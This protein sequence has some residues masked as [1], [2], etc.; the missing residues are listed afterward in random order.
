MTSGVIGGYA[1]YVENYTDGLGQITDQGKR[2]CLSWNMLQGMKHV[3]FECS[4]RRLTGSDI[5]I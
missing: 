1:T 4:E 5:Q 2:K 3:I